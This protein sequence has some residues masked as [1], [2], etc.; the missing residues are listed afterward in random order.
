[1]KKSTKCIVYG[2]T[3]HTDEGEFKNDICLP[4]YEMLTTG[5]IKP[6]TNFIWKLYLKKVNK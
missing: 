2:C 6:S 4:C 1:M 3:N 5:K